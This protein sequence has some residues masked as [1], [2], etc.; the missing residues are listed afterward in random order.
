[1]LAHI[2]RSTPDP[3]PPCSAP[4]RLTSSNCVHRFPHLPMAAAD[5]RSE[6]RREIDVLFPTPLSFPPGRG[7]VAVPLPHSRSSCWVSLLSSKSCLS[8]TLQAQGAKVPHPFTT[9]TP[10][11]GPLPVS[12]PNPAHTSVLGFFI[13]N[14]FHKPYEGPLSFLLG[15]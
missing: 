12:S 6:D 4:R 2:P 9:A 8:P 1:M 14:S 15:P 5:R 13:N 11:A 10:R 3:S 7:L